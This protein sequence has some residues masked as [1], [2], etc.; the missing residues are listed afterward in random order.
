MII[1]EKFYKKK[2]NV[3]VNGDSLAGTFSP[4]QF[5]VIRTITP[6]DTSKNKF[7]SVYMTFEA[8]PELSGSTTDGSVGG[9]VTDTGQHI[10]IAEACYEAALK[11]EYKL[12]HR[13]I[14]NGLKMIV[15]VLA[16]EVIFDSQ[17]K[18]RLKSIVKV[19]TSD[20]GDLVKDIQKVF[21]NNP[22]Y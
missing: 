4:Y 17:T 15:I 9:L 14:F 16:S 13:C 6:A 7:V 18:T 2:V 11:T 8:D 5:E 3:I 10:T 20:F 22:A 1:K 12:S 21:R 19:K